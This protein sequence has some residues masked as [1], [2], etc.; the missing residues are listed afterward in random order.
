[1]SSLPLPPVTLPLLPVVPP[2][3]AMRWSAL[4]LAAV[5]L[6]CHAQDRTTEAGEASITDAKAECAPYDYPPLDAQRTAFPP[7]S[8]AADILPNDTTAQS[9]WQ[10][11]V[12][13]VPNIP[14]KPAPGSSGSGGFKYPPG[15]PDCW[16]TGTQC[17]TPKLSGLPPDIADVPEPS[18]MGYGFD[19]GP[20]C[21]HNAFYNYL[22]SKN[23]KATMFYIG[24]NVYNWP[25]EAQRGLADGH[26]IC[27]HTWSHNYMTSLSS[28]SAFAEL[29]YTMEIIKLVVG[30]TPTCWR[31]PYGDVDDRIRA[32]AN[33]LGLRTILWKYDSFDWKYGSGGTKKAEIDANYQDVINKASN[34][35]FAS[36][37]AIMLTHE[38]NDFTMSEAMEYHDK[39]Q[40]VFKYIV[41]VGV[42]YNNTQAYVE[43]NYT[44]PTFEQ[45]ISGT[46][47]IPP[48]AQ[49]KL[50]SPSGSSSGSGGS[51]SAS[52]S[53]S[54][55]SAAVVT[56]P[57]THAGKWLL[58]TFALI[59][60]C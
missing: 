6:G 16:W 44:L 29:Y 2:A 26:E 8:K 45:Y 25:L 43:T 46:T 11:I 59:V 40:A 39:L 52:A 10:S 22:A 60:L 13:S 50:A 48:G 55:T 17:V 30:V 42:A 23:Q 56:L 24:T 4:I 7:P 32:I 47:T 34:G 14:P 57:W 19:D 1:M 28:S 54:P 21:S 33:G 12:S 20:S 9:R 37:G 5:T 35:S 15:D 18:T 41:P 36:A 51:T 58:V 38:L 27:V 31:P 49:A 3:V 53:P